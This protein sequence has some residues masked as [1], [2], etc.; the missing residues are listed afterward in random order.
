MDR[1]FAPQLVHVAIFSEDPP[2]LADFYE[3]AFDMKVV[4]RAGAVWLWDGRILLALNPWRDSNDKKVRTDEVGEI[5]TKKLDHFGF[6]VEK[7]EDFRD[8]LKKAGAESDP[9]PRPAGRSFSE[10]RFHDPDGNR[11]DLS[12]RGYK[13]VSS[14]QLAQIDTKDACE[15]NR[16]VT[17]SDNPSYLAKFFTSMFGLTTAS[18]SET[19]I[20]L[21]DGRTRLVILPAQPSSEKGLYCF[22]F[23]VT[24]EAKMSRRLEQMGIPVSSAPS[25]EDPSKRQFNTQDLDGNP[26]MFF[27]A[28]A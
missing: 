21:T 28:A 13:P 3:S 18:Q 6:R 1:A 22:G 11:I 24:D 26:L 23:Q 12:E 17:F 27:N 15:I 9:A 8:C 10:W 16:I 7:L 19:S 20:S 14:D 5:E 25:W 2:R 4:R